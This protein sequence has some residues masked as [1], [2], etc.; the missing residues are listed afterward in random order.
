MIGD[1]I[2]KITHPKHEITKTYNV[3]IVGIITD[4]EVERLKNG[5]DIGGFVT[6]KS[7]VKI[8]KIDN[9]KNNSRIQITI[10]EGKNR[11]IRKMCEAI[12]KKVLSLHRSKIGNIDVKDLKLGTWRYLKKQE[13]EKLLNN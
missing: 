3:T 1:F 10:H 12:G 8:L 9:E 7:K 11:Q 5:I 2:Y 13:I 6:S 4:E